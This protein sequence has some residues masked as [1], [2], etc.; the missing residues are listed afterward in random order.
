MSYEKEAYVKGQLYNIPIDH[1]L[2]DPDQPRKHLDPEA[3]EELTQSILRYGLLQPVLFRRDS[4]Q[5][6][7]VVAGERRMEA[8]RKADMKT[9]PAV[10]VE[11]KPAELSLIENLVRQNLT[12][13]EEAE[14]LQRLIE[15]LGYTQ[16]DLASIFSRS[17]ATISET[18]SLNRLPQHIRDDCRN[19]PSIPKRVLIVIAR[20]KQQRSMV[21][22]FK[23]YRER[24]FAQDK[25]K[26]RKPRAKKTPGRQEIAFFEKIW[27]RIA[28]I[29]LE[30]CTPEDRK[31]FLKILEALK[32]AIEEKLAGLTATGAL[33]GVSGERSSP[34]HPY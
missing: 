12:A 20:S 26:T 30:D 27:G 21:A 10:Y 28:A 32:G 8:A 13:M 22:L 17:K 2:A 3:L 1:L 5:R 16:D 6:L 19:D 4:D 14:A 34:D 24:Q 15:N 33:E 23:K 9:I 11:G 7:F 29:N 31:A 25:P 18:L